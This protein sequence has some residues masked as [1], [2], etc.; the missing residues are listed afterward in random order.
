MAISSRSK[1]ND[2]KSSEQVPAYRNRSQMA[3]APSAHAS[4]MHVMEGHGGER[5]GG[6]AAR[7]GTSGGSSSGG[8]KHVRTAS[9][10]P[11]QVQEAVETQT[12]DFASFHGDLYTIRDAGRCPAN[13]QV[14]ACVAPDD[15]DATQKLPVVGVPVTRSESS[16]AD[17]AISSLDEDP[18]LDDPFAFGLHVNEIGTRAIDGFV[19]G[20]S[21]V[22]RNVKPVFADT[23][24]LDGLEDAEIDDSF[25]DDL[26]EPMGEPAPGPDAS[27]EDVPTEGKLP[28][29]GDM[30][31][32]KASRSPET[33]TARSVSRPSPAEGGVR[34][35]TSGS[36]AGKVGR[37]SGERVGNVSRRADAADAGSSS[38]KAR[39][40]CKRS[41]AKGSAAVD[42]DRAAKASRNPGVA[43]VRVDSGFDGSSSPDE[44]GVPAVRSAAVGKGAVAVGRAVSGD[45]PIFE[46]LRFAQDLFESESERIQAEDGGSSSGSQART[47]RE[48]TDAGDSASMGRGRKVGDGSLASRRKRS[49][50]SGAAAGSRSDVRDGRAEGSKVPARARTG[51]MATG[52][53]KLDSAEGLA[54]VSVV[55]N[56]GAADPSPR[57]DTSPDNPGVSDSHTTAGVPRED[58]D[59]A[60]AD[61]SRTRVVSEL[62]SEAML[63]DAG[64]FAVA[65]AA[66]DAQQDAV[67]AAASSYVNRKKKS[68]RQKRKEEKERQALIEANRKPLLETFDS[69]TSRSGRKATAKASG[70]TMA[71][72]DAVASVAAVG[73]VPDAK[74]DAGGFSRDGKASK[75]QKRAMRSSMKV[76]RGSAAPQTDDGQ[77]H[78]VEAA[79]KLVSYPGGA[80]K[81]DAKAR[82]AAE[83]TSRKAARNATERQAKRAARNDRLKV[84]AIVALV[85]VVAGGILYPPARQYYISVRTLDEAEAELAELKEEN[86]ELKA[87]IEDLG[88]DDGIENYVREQYGWVDSGEQAV[89]V[90]GLTVDASGSSTISTDGSDE[91]GDGDSPLVKFLDAIFMVE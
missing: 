33:A 62:D 72:P 71:A 76:V 84:A 73:Q 67:E 22:E 12:G 47:S 27:A 31:A 5:I 23:A 68:R 29:E 49:D 65:D 57:A 18:M 44:D 83:K 1:R 60:P 32:V 11:S 17:K 25:L 53:G 6:S 81:S 85:V 63:A 37:A 64:D 4:G 40:S 39:A 45:E 30:L 90:T 86:Q 15:S 61:A 50:A 42:G 14:A 13:S 91:D 20:S 74:D 69:V 8:G 34:G 41:S 24:N 51:A 35:M 36:G 56:P 75:E 66:S 43:K 78:G 55:G 21:H 46:A 7:T 19:Y 80:G 59:A 52:H 2:Q 77:K 28:M 48:K 3:E 58:A 88:T 9:A 82:K 79:P 16:D 10:V 87:S 38:K 70:K 54:D 89:L 26:L